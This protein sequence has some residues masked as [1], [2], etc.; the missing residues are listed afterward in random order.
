MRGQRKGPDRAHRAAAGSR[1]R[2]RDARRSP[3][4]CDRRH[5]LELGP[6]RRLR[7]ARPC[8]AAALQ[9]E[10]ALPARGGPG[11]DRRDRGRG[12][13]RRTVEAVRRF[14]AIADA[15][16][17]ARIDATATEAIRRATNGP[18]LVA[19]I[20]RANPGW[21][22]AMLSGAEEATVR[23]A[24]RDLRLLPAGRPGRRHGRRQP[25]GRRGP[26][27]PGR[28]ALGQPAAR[29][30]AGRGAAG[31]RARRR[32]KRRDRRDARGSLPP[33]LT[34]PVV[35][36]RRRRLAG[37]RQGAHGGGR[38]AG[39]GGAWLHARR[40]ARRATSPRSSAHL[41][42]A[43]LAALPGVPAR[44]ART[45]PAAALVLDRVLKRLAPE[46]VVFSALGLRE[47]WLYSQLARDGALSRPAGRGRAAR[48]PAACARAGVRA[49]AGA[50]DRRLFPGE[51]PAETRLR[52]AVC[53]LSD[54]AWRDHPDCSRR[55]EL[56]PPAAVPVHRHRPCRARLHRGR[57]PRPLCR[58][59]RRPWLSPAI[60]A[61]RRRAAAAGRRSSAAR[62]CWPIASR[63]A[64]RSPGRRR[65]CGSS[66]DCVRLE[67]GTPRAFPTARSW[68]TASSFWRAPSACAAP[69]W[70]SSA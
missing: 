43:K 6:A 37:A 38:S 23:D 14:R 55:G 7:P 52:V 45:L 57:H 62:S 20:A 61:P 70:S 33:A 28:R 39:A 63:A 10:V 67:V 66:A 48:R 44:R 1:P 32:R 9:R 58:R 4:L 27:R 34:E 56:P 2:A 3:A 36:R 18:E 65:A 60:G 15:M 22:C 49:G 13:F 53:A 35:L 12:E 41:P 5:R 68:A 25:R 24:R 42:P 51:T 16:G 64:C 54:I 30:L 59:A 47:G 29:R 8:A 19:A 46:R 40:P 50:L 11:A 31:R 69:R 26:G 17:V 21:R